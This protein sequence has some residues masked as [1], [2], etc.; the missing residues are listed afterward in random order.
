MANSITPH[1]FG[2][3][4]GHSTLQKLLLFYHQ[5]ITFNDEIDVIYVDFYKAFDGVP[6][7]E[8]LVKL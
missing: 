6:Y 1:Q 7:N 3:Q 5:F 8:L 2:F 4:K